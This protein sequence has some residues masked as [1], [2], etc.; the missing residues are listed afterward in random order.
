VNETSKPE[1]TT[2]VNELHADNCEKGIDVEI[3][4]DNLPK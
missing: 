2:T 1:Q 3:L 4:Q